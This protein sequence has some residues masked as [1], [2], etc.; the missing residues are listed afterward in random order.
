MNKCL[1][2]FGYETP[3]QFAANRE[4]GWDDECNQVASSESE[5]LRWGREISE[6]FVAS[7]FRDSPVSWKQMNYAHG[8]EAKPEERYSAAEINNIPVVQV[9]QLLDLN[10]RADP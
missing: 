4:N 9:G 6:A 3:Q 8:I 10:V 7:L 5:A 1:Y 2:F